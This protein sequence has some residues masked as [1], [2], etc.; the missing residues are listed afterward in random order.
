[1]PHHFITGIVVGDE[2]PEL[3]VLDDN[4][5]DTGTE[6]QDVFEGFDGGL[7]FNNHLGLSPNQVVFDF[8]HHPVERGLRGVGDVGEDGV[9]QVEVDGLEHLR[10]QE[11][12]QHLSLA[13]DVGVVAA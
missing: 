10:H 8:C 9:F 6:R 7:S 13:I 1:M 5:F 4:L 3:G 11:F 12:S 2:G